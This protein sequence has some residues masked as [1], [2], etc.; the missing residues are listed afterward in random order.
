[1]PA[2]SGTAR[3]VTT[4]RRYK[5]R[6][7]RIH[8]VRSSYRADGKVENETLGNLSHLPEPLIDI[9][10]RTLQGETVVPL[11]QA[12]ET[13]A[14]RR[15]GHVQAVATAMRRLGLASVIAA[16]PSRER[17]PAADAKASRRWLD[18]GT[19]VHSFHAL[20]GELSTIVRNTSRTPEPAPI[21]RPSS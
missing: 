15:H 9:I 8:L 17:A 12:F 7:H 3:V 18:D 4:T 6:V 2:R 5:G 11:G 21:Q 14:S 19:A 10:R 16:K 13:T 20:L 1:M